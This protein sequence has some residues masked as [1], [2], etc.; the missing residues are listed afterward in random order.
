MKFFC[1]IFSLTILILPI[2]S[3][4]QSNASE[5]KVQNGAKILVKVPVS[6]ADR[7]QRYVTG[8]KKNDFR[9]YQDGVEQKIAS[10]STIVEPINVAL[11]LDTSGSTKDTLGKIKESAADFLALLDGQDKCL[12]ATF[13]SQVR[14]LNTLTDDHKLLKSLLDQIQTAEKN[15]SV[16]F[17]ALENVA[18]KSFV[19]VE[20]RKMIIVLSDGKDF[21]SS[22]S[23]S[24][25][26]SRL[27]ES[28]VPIYSIFYQ[29]GGGFNK[30][31]ISPDGKLTES[32]AAKKPKPEKPK[33]K[34]NTLMIPLSRDGYT[35]EEAKL[36]ARVGT[37]EA[38][39]SLQKL[40]DT[41]AGRFYPSDAQNLGEV[42][43]KIAGELRQIYQLG[44]YSQEAVA[45][46]TVH[47]IIVKVN[48]VD[49]VVRARGKFRATR[50]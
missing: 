17:D 29:T 48:R 3:V 23:K 36:L 24:E 32:K 19:G 47:Q 2:K 13:D 22:I 14:V 37:V 45:G 12:I 44:Y 35:E 16:L 9:L 25:L 33:K 34:K 6:V 39:N 42:F 38:V 31:N 40:S 28:D 8:L 1:A 20:G 26:V 49:A 15:G 43:K 41:T 21:G 50:L 30:L 27:E 7:D 4:S 11:L 46:E 5:N 10:F 18:Q